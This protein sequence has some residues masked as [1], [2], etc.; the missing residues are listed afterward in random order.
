MN[1]S[2]SIAGSLATRGIVSSL[3]D[4][5]GFSKSTS[6]PSSSGHTFLSGSTNAGKERR[7]S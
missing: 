2:T 7:P 1:S 6:M 4:N 5:T 3:P